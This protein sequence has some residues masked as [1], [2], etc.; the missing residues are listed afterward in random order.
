MENFK[1][2]ENGKYLVSDEGRVFRKKKGLYFEHKT[3]IN[4]GYVMYERFKSVHRLVA[5]AFIDNPDNKAEV[6]HKDGVKTNNNVCNLE[7]M[8]HQENV[9]H[10]WDNGLATKSEESGVAKRPIICVQTQCIYPSLY[11]ASLELD[12]PT[13][14]IYRAITNKSKAKG[15]N[16]DYIETTQNDN[17]Y[18]YIS[19]LS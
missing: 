18:V 7:W 8:T 1:I 6:N 13:S 16:F 14:N 17:E 12:I 10:A 9:Q 4:K 2:V 5:I 3:R 19:Q 15:L 11:S